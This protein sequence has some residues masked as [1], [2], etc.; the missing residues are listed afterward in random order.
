MMKMAKNEGAN[1]SQKKAPQKLKIKNKK[2]AKNLVKN[3]FAAMKEGR[4]KVFKKTEIDDSMDRLNYKLAQKLDS[5]GNKELAQEVAELK[6]N[7]GF[8]KKLRAWYAAKPLIYRIGTAGGGVLSVCVLFVLVALGLVW[9]RGA[10]IPF[11]NDL[12]DNEPPVLAIKKDAETEYGVV[13]ENNKFTISTDGETAF[14]S[15]GIQNKISVEPKLDAEVSVENNSESLVITPSEDL[16]EGTEYVVTLA[17][18]TMFADGSALQEDL[19]WVFRTEP[20]FAVTGITPRD[21]STSAPVDTTIEME[22]NYK[23]IDPQ[24]FEDYFSMTPNVAGKF[25][26]HG[27][28]I[29]F[30]PSKNLTGNYM[31]KVTV[32]EGL[33]RG[34]GDTLQNSYTSEF[35]VT[36]SDSSGKYVPQPYLYWS[37]MSPILSVNRDL[38]MGMGSNDLSHPIEF[39]LYSAQP[40]AVA[41]A[42]SKYEGDF[43]EKPSSEYLEEISTFS[44]TPEQAQFFNIDFGNYGIYLLEA[45]NSDVGRRM[46]KFI[47]YSP[48]G[49]IGS[50][51]KQSDQVW[52]FNMAQKSPQ[53]GANIE[54]YDLASGRLTPVGTGRTGD[55][56]HA[57]YSD[58]GS[59]LIIAEL[60]GNYAIVSEHSDGSS[61]WYMGGWSWGE[62]MSED[63]RSFVYTDRPLYRPG[64]TVNFKAVVRAESDMDYEIPD[65]LSV[66]IRVGENNYMWDNSRKVPIYEEE[67]NVSSDYGTV[68]GSFELPSNT[69]VGFNTIS[70]LVGDEIGGTGYFNVAHY[71]KPEYQFSL[72]TSKDYAFDG[73]RVTVSIS[74][75]DY[76]GDPASGARVKL[77]VGRG[78]VGYANWISGIDE[79]E[80]LQR[81][82]YASEYIVD[83]VITLNNQGKASYTFTVDTDDYA[84]NLG[85]YSITISEE[86]NYSSYDSASVVAA[87]SNIALWMEPENYSIEEGDDVDVSL[88]TT[89]LWNWNSQGGVKV[90]VDV[91]RSWTEWVE[92]GNYY[93]PVTKSTKP[94]YTSVS[95]SEP[96][97]EG[98]ELT[99]DSDG[100]AT[101]SL[102]N[103]DNGS[104]SVAAT[105]Y[106]GN[107]AIQKDFDSLFYVYEPPDDDA[108]IYSDWS[109]AYEKFKMYFDKEAYDVGDQAQ[110]VVKTTLD[111]KG[112]LT[113]HRGD[114]YDWK[115]MDFSDGIVYL[116]EEITAQMAPKIQVCA[117][118]IDEFSSSESPYESITSQYLSD[119]FIDHCQTV[120]VNTT[121]GKLNVEVTPAQSEYAPGD[122]VTLDVR[123]TDSGGKGVQTEVSIDVVDEALLDLLRGGEE[124]DDFMGYNIYDSF[125]DDVR[126]WADLNGSM[127][128]YSYMAFRGA[129]GGGDTGARENF[130]DAAYWNGTVVTDGAGRAQV[131]FTLPDNLTTW[132]VHAVAVSSD[133]WV[134]QGSADFVARQDIRLDAKMP[135]FLRNGDK[136]DFELGVENFSGST[137]ASTIS[138][139]CKGC[140]EGE[141]SRNVNVAAGTRAIETFSLEIAD[142]TD[143]LEL[144]ISLGAGDSKYDSVVWRVPVAGAGLLESKSRSIYMTEGDDSE[145]MT[146]SIPEEASADSADLDLTF[147]RSYINEHALVTVDPTVNSSIELAGSIIH[148]GVILKH[149]D[150]IQPGESRGVYV[151]K[152]ESAIDMVAANQA[153][154]GGF[155]WFD[156]DAVNY[157]VSSY[158]GVALGVA[159][160]A[161]VDVDT[162]MIVNLRMYLWDVLNSESATI[163]EKVYAVYALASLD[164]SSV[165]PY[166]LELKG[167]VE[168]FEDSPLSVAHLMLALKEL[169]SSGDAGELLPLLEESAEVSDRS[170]TWQD[171]DT[172]FRVV[173]TVEY[174][175]AVV[176]L[177]LDNFGQEEMADKA[178]NWLVDNPVSVYGNSADAVSVFYALTEANIDNLEGRKGVNK[179]SVKVNGQDVRTFDVDGDEEWIGKVSLTVPNDVLVDGENKIEVERSGDGDLYV[180]GNLNYYTSEPDDKSEFTVKRYVKD[181]NSGGVVSGV[182]KGQVVV[183]RTEVTVDRDAYNMVV[184]DFIPSGFEPV[185][186]ELG[187]YDYGFVSR[188][189]QWGSGGYT[190]RYGSVAQDRV[191]FTEY[192]VEEGEKY[193]F[194][195]PLVAAYS[196][197]FSGAGAQ[198]YLVNFGDIGGY[199]LSG[200]VTVR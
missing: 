143:E 83:S 137:V 68:T 110:I 193:V 77:L 58:G 8:W 34:N 72:E 112:I 97:L 171:E 87:Q 40:E 39:T 46:Y 54:F 66:T 161:G 37:D 195:Y 45:Y 43:Y 74:G 4:D 80:E 56:G 91:T 135:Q 6:E 24:K 174:T 115:V 88:K 134:G 146:M 106:N 173:K 13:I 180:V 48:I 141:F 148:N 41:E 23:D 2:K 12:Y 18:G 11:L 129:G 92:N 197:E 130:A 33:P 17:K 10:N 109:S 35:R 127:R 5:A 82:H 191:T 20:V 69:E 181:F 166:A 75:E 183:V 122:E 170:A 107:S 160:D 139:K 114:V 163:D 51:S 93:D 126:Q 53:A 116:Q 86:G 138:G 19:K 61:W 9:Y 145:S 155:G 73:E 200:N 186:Y 154:S 70:V 105:Y 21:G 128:R 29:V 149:Y 120:E 7:P 60:S 1:K 26:A 123:V 62:Q 175:T 52:V 32:K 198:G 185:Q 103:L 89:K 67:F 179:V 189:W 177:A 47:V 169:G 165:L 108:P 152:L 150:Q 42:M 85:V 36:N 44:R 49:M 199:G 59:D 132:E 94:L 196:G 190:N 192:R 38:W 124:D 142:G 14:R 50:N 117:W 121:R 22:L 81:W 3:F 63:Y 98:E 176:Y 30:L 96:V 57:G 65:D 119:V 104:Y 144:E 28:K 167:G 151:E 125:Y 157:E 133:T 99:T 71:V 159:R 16:E 78:E 100:N 64:D 194:E 76:A 15:W 31:Y 187:S 188:W 147:A 172:P 118:G 95:H 131:K 153:E 140:T 168:E 101:L 158:V 182:R 113:V 55:S 79:L 162:G 90:E 84:S 178:R 156:Y 102:T 164:D 184:Q 25:E 111:G 27:K 136:W